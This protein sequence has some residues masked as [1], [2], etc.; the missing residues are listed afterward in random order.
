M[1]G[2]QTCALPISDWQ[3][4][5]LLNRNILEI[6]CGRDLH[7]SLVA[8]IKYNRKVISFDIE[9]IANLDLI[10]YTA[11]KLGCSL[12][13]NC[14]E[15]LRRI[16]ILYIV[17]KDISKITGYKDIVSTAVMEHIPEDK[18]MDIFTTAKKNDVESITANIDFKDHWSYVENVK[19]DNF[20]YISDIIWSLINNKKMYQNRL[21]FSDINNMALVN[22]FRIFDIVKNIDNTIK[23][24]DNIVKYF[25]K[26]SINDLQTM[27]VMVHWKR[28]VI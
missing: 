15:D 21:R 20:Y 13:F 28:A 3:I 4:R 10:N 14:L 6:G 1:T 17:D 25:K 9:R 12:K 11:S 8:A 19:P 26:Y 22:G 18:L 16:G 27:N 2:V 5:R 7:T 23:P 24:R